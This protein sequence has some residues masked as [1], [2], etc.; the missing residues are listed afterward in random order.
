M[1]TFDDMKKKA[2][3]LVESAENKGYEFNN[4]E[5]PSPSKYA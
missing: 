2:A 4:I 5:P 3:Y 1:N